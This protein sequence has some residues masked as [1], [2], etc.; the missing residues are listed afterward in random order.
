LLSF[1]FQGQ[2]YVT[3]NHSDSYPK[4]LGARIV[5]FA[6]DHLKGAEAIQAFGRKIAALEWVHQARDARSATPQGA[7]LL[8]A[9]AAGKLAK[10]I[11]NSE[12]FRTCLDC[13]F[14]YI[15]DL[16]AGVLEFWNLPD[17]VETFPLASI[18]SCAVDIMECERCG[19]CP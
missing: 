7:D 15:L 12:L 3:Y 4:G 17:R 19:R 10:V 14:A 9:I 11:S 18:S 16:D 6:Q 8:A 2:D 13:E 1:H 5:R